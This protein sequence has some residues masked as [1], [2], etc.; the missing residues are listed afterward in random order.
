[1]T[2]NKSAATG[3]APADAEAK[4]VKSAKATIPTCRTCGSIRVL[5][6]AWAVWDAVLG[7]WTL[8][9]VFDNAFCPD[10]DHETRIVWL[11]KAPDHAAR[12][13]MLNDAFRVNG[14]GNGKVMITAGIR[15][16][17][18]HFPALALEAVRSFKAFDRDNDPHGEHD[19]GSFDLEGE[20]LF[21]K[22]DC[23]APGLDAGS[24]DPAIGSNT[25]RVLT[26][27]LAEEY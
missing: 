22:I 10:C 23:Y 4:V 20:K 15:A 2:T 17:G 27:M 14:I 6:D 26:I 5:R 18:D 24:E 8:G 16:K 19:F 25:V 1:M 12:I 9:E 7:E 11:E 3:A 21:F 13:R